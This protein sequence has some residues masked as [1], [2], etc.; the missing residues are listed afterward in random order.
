MAVVTRLQSCRVS[1][2]QFPGSGRGVTDSI[3]LSQVYILKRTS[4]RVKYGLKEPLRRKRNSPERSIRIWSSR[5]RRR[6]NPQLLA[7]VRA[8]VQIV[9]RLAL[10]PLHGLISRQAWVAA[11]AATICNWQGRLRQIPRPD[12]ASH[13]RT[14]PTPSGDRTRTHSTGPLTESRSRRIVGW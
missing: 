5:R 10:I 3:V 12:H 6:A 2:A 7:V 14:T 1:L 4:E 8:T 11:V 13:Y 9:F